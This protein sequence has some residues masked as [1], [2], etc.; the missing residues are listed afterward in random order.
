MHFSAISV[1]CG[2]V[3]VELF[4]TLCLYHEQTVVMS[5]QKRLIFRKYSY[6]VFTL[7]KLMQKQVSNGL[8]KEDFQS[9]LVLKNS[10]SS[11]STPNVAK[12]YL[13]SDEVNICEMSCYLL[14]PLLLIL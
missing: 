4:A 10:D 12:F 7:H 13:A 8:T 14:H 6:N 11:G 2:T 5:I 9:Q 1:T 3:I